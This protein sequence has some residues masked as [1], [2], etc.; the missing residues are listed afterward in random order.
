MIAAEGSDLIALPQRFA[1]GVREV[2][3]AIRCVRFDGQGAMRVSPVAELTNEQ[4]DAVARA[5]VQ[6]NQGHYFECHE[7]LEDVWRDLRGPSRDFFQ[8]L[9]QV[10]VGFLHLE[11]GNRV[12][13]VRTFARALDRFKPYPAHYLGFEVATERGR[14]Q[15]RLNAL[16]AGVVMGPDPPPIWTYNPA[17]E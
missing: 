15:E 6:F 17:H 14:V 7:T 13:A 10:S 9:I 8:A 5:V 12:G 4:R 1:A 11:R 2:V 16:R 3:V